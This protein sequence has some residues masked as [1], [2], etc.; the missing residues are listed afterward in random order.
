MQIHS[1]IKATHAVH[2][3]TTLSVITIQIHT[4]QN[5]AN[6]VKFPIIHLNARYSNTQIRITFYC[7]MTALYLTANLSTLL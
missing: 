6:P 4:I 2:N 1:R 3:T 5:A 7:I